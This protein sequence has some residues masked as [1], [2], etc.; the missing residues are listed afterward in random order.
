[1]KRAAIALT[2]IALLFGCQQQRTSSATSQKTIEVRSEL[3]PEQLGELGAKI[4]KDPS[5]AHE[6][7]SS[8]GLDDQ[9]FE[10]AIR[11]VTEDPAAS[12]RYAA[13]YKSAGS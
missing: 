5:H 4:R 13:A 3:T 12:K 11:K 10:K 2:A 6:L 1:M 8:H 9:S 7:L